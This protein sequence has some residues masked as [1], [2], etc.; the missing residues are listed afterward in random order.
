MLLE[1]NGVDPDRADEWRRTPLS[2]AAENG[3]EGIARILVERNDVNLN[4][5]DTEY[6]RTPLSWAAKNGHEG[7]VRLLLAQSD[8]SPNTV[9][10]KH[11]QT[12]LY[13]SKNRY[14]G[15][16]VLLEQ[17]EIIPDTTDTEYGRTPLWWAT[18]KVY[19]GIAK[20]LQDRAHLIPKHAES[21]Q[22]TEPLHSG[23]PEPSELPS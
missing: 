14:E 22:L 13:T 11:G 8:I 16:K 5:V 1:R 4:I 21:L 10:I 3:R 19:K 17:K 2:L 6:G 9:G 18:K 15:V 12:P 20:L 23:A 7:I